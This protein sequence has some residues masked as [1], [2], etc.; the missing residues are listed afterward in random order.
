MNIQHSKRCNL[1][2]SELDQNP[3]LVTSASGAAQQSML[4]DKD[5]ARVPSHQETDSW[6][7]Y[8]WPSSSLLRQVWISDLTWTLASTLPKQPGVIRGVFRIFP[9]FSHNSPPI[10]AYWSYNDLWRIPVSDACQH[11]RTQR[12]TSH[13]FSWTDECLE[14]LYTVPQGGGLSCFVQSCWGRELMR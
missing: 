14:L 11:K 5:T 13:R 4:Q 6:T 1:T 12:T 9:H 10:Q 7:L 8:W 3:W 2:G